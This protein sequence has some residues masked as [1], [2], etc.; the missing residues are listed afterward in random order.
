MAY[1]REGAGWTVGT[2]TEAFAAS[3]RSWRRRWSWRKIDRSRRSRRLSSR[4]SKKNSKRSS[5]TSGRRAIRM[6]SIERWRPK[7]GRSL[8]EEVGCSR[9]HGVYDGRGNVVWPGR[10]EDV[11]IDRGRLDVVNAAFVEAF[12]TSPLASH[13]RL[14]PS[15][16]YAATPL[17]GVGELSLSAQRERADAASSAG[18]GVGAAEDLQRHGGP[19]VRS[20]ARR[21]TVVSGRAIAVW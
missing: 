2:P 6:R 17:T 12:G 15:D 21:T 5:G 9:R 7:A 14:M 10:H 8:L 16:G 1:R 13:G 11:G 4:Q 19:A 20:S 18:T 3:S